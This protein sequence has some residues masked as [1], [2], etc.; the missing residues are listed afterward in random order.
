MDTELLPAPLKT[1]IDT[2]FTPPITLLQHGVDYLNHVS[3]IAGQGIN[4]GN[5]LGFVAFLPPV[6][7][8]VMNSLISS[9]I[10][11]AMLQL[12]KT[13]AATYYNVKEGV[14]WW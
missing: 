8:T 12:I 11:L 4:L 10:F 2:I 7:Q 6:F 3:L 14:K 9:V 1:F 5:Y 13:I